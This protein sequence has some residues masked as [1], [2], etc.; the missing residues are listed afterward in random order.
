MYPVSQDFHQ[1]MQADKRR[2]VARATIDYTDPFMDQSIVVTPGENAYI[3]YP[4]HTADGI[5]E[6]FAK[7][8]SLDGNWKLGGGWGLAPGPNEAA[9]RQ[10]GWWGKK[11]SGTG[12]AFTAP[13][14]MLAV[15]FHSR[16]IDSLS[17]TGD[18]KR[19]EWPVNFTIKLYDKNNSALHTE[20]VTGNTEIFWHKALSSYITGVVKQELVITKWSHAG[21]QVKILEYFTSLQETYEM[22]DL[23]EI[24]LLEEREIGI[25]T[26]PIGAIS[27]NEISLKLNNGDRKFDA[28]N[29]NSLLCQLLKPNRR[30]RVWMGMHN[31]ECL[32]TW[33]DVVGYTWNDL[34][35]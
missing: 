7:Y 33:R 21:Q 29:E 22:D 23:V 17:V 10:M 25:G 30:I 2:V 6:P 26:I 18:S 9:F 31:V 27:A 14:P 19:K 16:P 13:Y 34:F 20:T 12:G 15:T 11:L 5:T 3:S 35:K 28:D 4:D 24:R 1:G 32:A 8:A